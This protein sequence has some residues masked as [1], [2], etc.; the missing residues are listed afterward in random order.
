MIT[1]SVRDG[2]VPTEL[3]GILIAL[4]VGERLVEKDG[5]EENAGRPCVRGPRWLVQAGPT[6][7]GSRVP[8]RLQWAAQPRGAP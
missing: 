2:Y 1:T 5:A 4:L 8:Y 7:Y 6:H 3:L